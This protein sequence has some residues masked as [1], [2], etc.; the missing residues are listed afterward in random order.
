MS[1]QE[2]SE[3]NHFG[4]HTEFIYVDNE[5]NEDIIEEKVYRE[6]N[7]NIEEK[8]EEKDAEPNLYLYT[9]SHLQT[10]TQL[11]L[12]IVNSDINLF[13]LYRDCKYTIY[14][15][16][17]PR[18]D[19][20]PPFSLSFFD[21]RSVNNFISTICIDNLL[22]STETYTFKL[23]NYNNLEQFKLSDLTYEFFETWIDDAYLLSQKER[24]NMRTECINTYIN[25]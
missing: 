24:V 7:T 23:Y 16:R 8:V 20:N 15:K 14:G 2:L 1:K 13:L 17:D 12:H 22:V 18:Q 11:V 25:P 4:K 5:D 3:R 9:E 6:Y 21:F 10:H 19:V